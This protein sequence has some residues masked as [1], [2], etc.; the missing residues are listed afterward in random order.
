[1]NKCWKGIRDIVGRKS[2]R[3]V[4]EKIRIGDVVQNDELEIANAFNS[5]FAGVAYDLRSKLPVPDDTP[6]TSFIDPLQS[7]FYIHP[8]TP[9]ECDNIISKLKNCSYGMNSLSTRVLK[10]ISRYIAGPLS[11]LVNES[12]NTGV[13]P[14]Q[15][16]IATITP[17]FKAG[18]PYSHVKL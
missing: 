9:K 4:V 5:Y 16:K 12:F 17:I 6:V 3:K 8:V 14:D 2:D 13:F 15:L 10:L 1:M 18:D 11:V 7:S